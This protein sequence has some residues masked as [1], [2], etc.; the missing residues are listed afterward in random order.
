MPSVRYEQ[1]ESQHMMYTLIKANENKQMKKISTL[2][3]A[4]AV[5]CRHKL[6]ETNVS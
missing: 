2:L 3:I 5:I 4:G 6:L 1:N